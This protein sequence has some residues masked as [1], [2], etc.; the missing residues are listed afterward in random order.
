MKTAYLAACI[1]CATTLQTH[2]RLGE[3]IDACTRRYGAPVNSSGKLS[4]YRVG[5]ITIEIL[6]GGFSGKDAVALRYTKPGRNNNQELSPAE[7]KQILSVNTKNSGRRWYEIDPWKKGYYQ[8]DE[9]EREEA[10]QRSNRLLEWK[11]GEIDALATYKRS[12]AELCIHL[13]G[14]KMQ[15][16]TTTLSGL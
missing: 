1:I 16:S 14:V 13:K 15:N 5:A 2:A 8:M 11:H 6:F 9:L 3:S 10:A 4:T 7:I 12:T